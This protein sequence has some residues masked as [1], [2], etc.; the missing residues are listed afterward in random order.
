LLLRILFH[1]FLI[2]TAFLPK[3]RGNLRPFVDNCPYNYP[4]GA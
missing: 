2:I 4:P 3:I 1:T